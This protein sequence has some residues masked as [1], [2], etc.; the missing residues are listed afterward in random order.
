MILT[1]TL[2]AQSLIGELCLQSCN[3]LN[4]KDRPCWTASMCLDFEP[5][6]DYRKRN[7]MNNMYYS[8][9]AKVIAYSCFSTLS[10]WW[11]SP[12]ISWILWTFVQLVSSF[13]YVWPS[14]CCRHPR[15]LGFALLLILPPYPFIY[16][17]F[18]GFRHIRP[19][20]RQFSNSLS[21]W[22]PQVSNSV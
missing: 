7:A 5:K 11:F 6:L 17:L 19:V 8:N 10:H 15:S 20:F 14:G 22:V 18:H 21:H 13:V 2:R 12:G 3:G 16:E 4:P 1:P 9:A